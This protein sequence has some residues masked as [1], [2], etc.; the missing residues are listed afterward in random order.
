MDSLKMKM[1]L[2]V[3]GV[4]A[5]LFRSKTFVLELKFEIVVQVVTIRSKVN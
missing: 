3:S 4:Q 1:I 5:K 2:I